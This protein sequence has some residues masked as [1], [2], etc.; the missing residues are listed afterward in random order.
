MSNGTNT[1]NTMAETEAAN[2]RLS[3][4][5]N[6]QIDVNVQAIATDLNGAQE[7]TVTNEGTISGDNIDEVKSNS[8]THIVQLKEKQTTNEASVNNGIDTSDEPQNT[9]D[10]TKTYKISGTAWLDA[11]ENGIR[12]E[13]ENRMESVTAMLVDSSSGVIKA[14]TTTNHN[15]EYTFS[16]LQN[17]S[18]LVIFKYDTVLYTTTTYRKEGV[19]SSINSDAVATKIEQEGKRENGA[20]TDTIQINGSNVAN[21]DLGLVQAEKF[22]LQLDKS[23]TKITVQNAQG[24]KTETFDKTKLAKYDIAAKYLAGTT[25]YVEYTLT[26]TNNGD[27]AGFASEIVDYMPKGMTFN[28][29]LNPDWYTGTDGYLY[30]KALAN[31]ELAKG[32]SKEITLV[33]TKQMTAENTGNVSNTAE[34]SDDFNIYSVSDHNS[35]P[36]NKAQGEDDMSTADT[37]LTVKTGESLIYVSAIIVS[38]MIGG[39]VAFIVY[40]RVLKNKRKGGV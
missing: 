5:A 21:V 1:V 25:V 15:G 30:T 31:S 32:E 16:G 14:T 27:L 11:N 8:V 37:I 33:L 22:S 39:A 7:K 13:G 4:P 23:I 26:I 19:E 17:G 2:L 18:Y 40:E 28:S 24:T 20:V 9:G 6:S 12:D 36:K 35:T 3:V 38:I 34:I 29:S 10:I